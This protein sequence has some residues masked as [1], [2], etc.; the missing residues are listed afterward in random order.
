MM[1]M[2]MMMTDNEESAEY[3]ILTKPT[4]PT[5]K[6]NTNL[7]S[8]STMGKIPVGFFSMTSKQGWLSTN[9]TR[10]TSKPSALYL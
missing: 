9:S 3:K 6:K 2:M 7:I 1:M 4:K 5:T 10:F 8:S